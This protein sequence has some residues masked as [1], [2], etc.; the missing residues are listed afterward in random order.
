[1]PNTIHLLMAVP[2]RIGIL[3]FLFVGLIDRQLE[4]NTLAC[5]LSILYKI[6]SL[7]A[8]CDCPSVFAYFYTPTLVKYFTFLM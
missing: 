2:C 3:S 7:Q 5:L 6:L 1:M 8:S 4:K